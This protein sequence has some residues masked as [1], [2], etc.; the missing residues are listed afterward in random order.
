MLL[1]EFDE[2]EGFNEIRFLQI[3][4]ILLMACGRVCTHQM[5]DRWIILTRF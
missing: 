2:I 4:A 1:G 5:S 3:R